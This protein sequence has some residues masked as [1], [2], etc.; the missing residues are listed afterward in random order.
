MA[1]L[2]VL[3]YFIDHICRSLQAPLLVAAVAIDL[4]RMV[5]KPFPAGVGFQPDHAPE[6][7][8]DVPPMD[9]ADPAVV[10]AGDSG[11]LQAIDA[12]GLMDLACKKDLVL[13]L[14]CRPGDYVVEGNPLVR[15]EGHGNVDGLTVQSLS[16]LFLIGRQRTAEQ[17][18]EYSM[19]QLV[20]VAVRALS[21]GINDPFTAVNCVDWI[22]AAI[23]TI[24]RTGLPSAYRNDADGN[25]RII[26][27]V[28]SFA[29]LVDQAFNQ[30]RQFGAPEHRG[31][32]PPTRVNCLLCAAAPQRS[33]QRR[34]MAHQAEMIFRQ[35]QQIVREPSDLADIAAAYRSAMNALGLAP[36]G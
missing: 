32:C 29:G 22:G 1:S 27:R 31:D 15:I 14:A 17:D 2:V 10:T 16:R 21:P 35:S 7:E 25:P 34:V 28:T 12:D 5:C 13:R 33:A 8:Q 24:A 26:A 3:I 23:A 6:V 18:V 4:Q 36:V 30:I 11:Y 20:E 9:P 19:R